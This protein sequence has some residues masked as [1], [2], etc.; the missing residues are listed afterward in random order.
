[1]RSEGHM[2]G[3]LVG[4]GL[5]SLGKSAINIDLV[6]MVVEQTR[7]ADKRKPFL[8]GAAAVLLSGVAVWAASQHLVASKA[9]DKA[10]TMSEQRENLAPVETAISQ[11]LKKE[12]DLRKVATSYTD[13]ESARAFWMDLL[14]EVRG[15][16]ASD[17][18]WLTDL[19]PLSG[20]D[21]AFEP[22]AGM[23]K[24]AAKAANGKS[25][26]KADY[27][28]VAY[29][30][31]ALNEVRTEVQEAPTKK[32]QKGA[33]APVGKSSTA[34]AVRIKGFWRE[35]DKG[36]NVVLEL[37]KNLRERST[38]FQFKTKNSK[39]A[40]VILSDE[41]L[42]DITV[43]GKAGELGLPFEITLPLAREVVIK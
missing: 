13:A 36:Q 30:L 12:D 24:I 9:E 26:V 40:E 16:F 39:G 11:L 22:A 8:V 23:T 19:E 42:L 10:Q 14:G 3:E 35:T 37:L 33:V 5:R 34:N 38:S 21:P 4:L 20:Y 25:V 2:M 28:A 15:A 29:G 6:P 27:M 1:V 18:V 31:S 32:S 17:A 43:T 7:A 41:R